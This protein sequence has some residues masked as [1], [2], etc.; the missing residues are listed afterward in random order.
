MSTLM[1]TAQ[2]DSLVETSWPIAVLREEI[3]AHLAAFKNMAGEAWDDLTPKILFYIKMK[4]KLYNSSNTNTIFFFNY[5]LLKSL[6][7]T[8]FTRHYA[9]FSPFHKL[10]APKLTQQMVAL[11]VAVI[12]NWRLSDMISSFL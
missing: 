1:R 9:F 2:K 12:S 6:F 11:K 7:L 8:H 10:V 5:Y 4:F 3:V